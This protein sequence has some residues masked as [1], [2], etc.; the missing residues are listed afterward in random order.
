MNNKQLVIRSGIILIAETL[1]SHLQ[2]LSKRSIQKKKRK[3]K[4]YWVRPWILR[5]KL[6]GISD[7]L[8]KELALEDIHT[9]KN[10]LRMDTNKFD[11]LL[12]LVEP[13]I[14]KQDTQF[15]EAIPAATRL[16]VTLR[17]LASGD[18]YKTLELM[19]RIPEPTL[20]RMIPDVLEAIVK[21]LHEYINVRQY[22]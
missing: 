7:T 8:C 10:M 14:A 9:F 19:F 1:K 20:S 21:V 22:I 6:F 3:K 2:Q 5:R 4:K 12:R 17:F 11:E 16:Q 18:S 13:I 15:R